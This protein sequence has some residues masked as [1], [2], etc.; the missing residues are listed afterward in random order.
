MVGAKIVHPGLLMDGAS[1]YELLDA[2]KVTMT[3]AVPT[4]WLML[5]AFLEE[6]GKKPSHLNRVVIGGSACPR[7][8]TEAFQNTYDVEVIYAW[9]MT[10]MSPLG[11]LGSMKLQYSD[12]SGDAK[13]D[14]QE[15]Q[16][17]APFGVEMKVTDDDV[18][19]P[20]DGKTF[21]KLKVWS[22]RGQN[23][24]WWGGSRTIR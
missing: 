5:L 17:Y 23:L 15:K 1:I 21:G 19:A 6:S 3:A 10:E 20:W 14:I 11:S 24:L 8:M 12:L 18:E 9:G 4:V 22:R 7:A 16:G 2:E 13:L